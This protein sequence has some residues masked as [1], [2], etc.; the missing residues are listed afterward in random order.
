MNCALELVVSIGGAR[1]V[2]VPMELAFK[3]GGAMN[4][5]LV[6]L[7]V[8][9][10][11]AR[12]VVVPMELAFKIGGAM[13]CALELVVAIG[14]ART[15][16]VP[17]ELAFKIGGAMNCALE[18]VVLCKNSCRANGT[19]ILVFSCIVAIIHGV[20]RKCCIYDSTSV[21]EFDAVL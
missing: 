18:L 11:G 10:G 14:G 12:T 3:I 13:N 16:V 17:M 6:E 4:C 19:C 20:I 7:V 15:V 2:V 21:E 8:S 9:I 5:A 1:T